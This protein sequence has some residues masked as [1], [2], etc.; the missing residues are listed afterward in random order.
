MI[1]SLCPS[2]LL[3]SLLLEGALLLFCLALEHPR[4]CGQDGAAKLLEEGSALES[5]LETEL[6]RR[7]HVRRQLVD[8]L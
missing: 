8:E 1:S 3:P 4:E 6:G 2:L 5:I 7:R